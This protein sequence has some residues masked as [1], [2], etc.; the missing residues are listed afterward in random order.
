MGINW[1]QVFTITAGILV[2]A[3]VLTVVGRVRA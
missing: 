2:A 1:G 3:V